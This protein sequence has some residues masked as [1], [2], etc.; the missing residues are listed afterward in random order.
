MGVEFET[1]EA[2]PVAPAEVLA[3][4]IADVRGYTSFTRERGDA[5]AAR[6]ATRFAALAGDAVAARSGEVVEV[7]GDE[8]FAVFRSAAQAVTAALELQATLAEESAADPSLPLP[9]GI[10]IA[11]G[12]AVRVGEGYRGSALNLAARLCSRAVAGQ[13][14]VSGEVFVRTAE[15]DV[16]RLQKLGHEALK[17]F[18][19]PVSVYEA[20]AAAGRLESPPRSA[21]Q[22]EPPMELT[23]ETPL[24]GREP[25]L[26]WLRGTWRSARR[27]CG[28]IV[29][30][31]G[32]AG[33]GKTSLAAALAMH[34]ADQG[35][36][37]IYSGIGGIA[38]AQVS[39]AAG[40]AGSAQR[41]TRVVLD[42]LQV[43]GATAAESLREAA[44]AIAAAP[45]LVVGL[46]DDLDASPELEDI[47]QL[48]DARGDGHRRLQPLQPSEV[49]QVARGYAPDEID[50]VPVE[51][52]A[53]RSGGM[54]AAV[55]ELLDTWV[56][57]ESARR[58]E[59]AAEWLAAGQK[60]R[61]AQL[62]FA[63]TAIERRLRRIYSPHQIATLPRDECPYQGLAPYAEDDAQWFFGRERLIGELAA[64]T[65]AT[66]LLAVVGPS[67]SGK[68]SVVRAGL[69]PSL[70]AGLLPG[71]RGWS[72]V[73]IRPGARPHAELPAGALARADSEHRLLLAVD[74]FEEVFTLCRDSVEREAFLDALVEAAAAPER[75]VVIVTIRGDYLDCV[76]EHHA[77]AELVSA[78]Q[79]LVG[80][81]TPDE[82]RRVVEQPAHRCGVRIESALADALVDEATGQPGALPLLSTA[83]VELWGQLSG[84]WLRMDAYRETGGLRGA[85]A[86]LAEASY[87]HLG[88]TEQ[89][90]A[91]R[92]FLRLAGS[93]EG[94]TVTRR[95]VDLGEF[96]TARDT[97]AGAVLDRFVADRLLTRT[98]DAVEVAHEAL[99]REW[100]RLREWLAEDAQG[101]QLHRHL[102]QAAAQW[103][104]NGRRA[105]DLYRAERLSAATE[106]S[107]THAAELNTLERE[108]LT[109]SQVANTRA[110]RRLRTGVAVLAALL[111]LSLVAGVI[112]LSQRRTAQSAATAAQR[113]AAAA[114][115][116]ARVATGQ[117]LGLQALREPEIGLSLQ[118]AAQA[119][120]IDPSSET[121]RDLVTALQHASPAVHVFRASQRL[122]ALAVT[123]DG[124][125]LAA[126]GDDSA[127][128]LYD[129]RTGRQLGRPIPQPPGGIDPPDVAFSPDGRTLAIA[130]RSPTGA[131]LELVDV[132]TRRVISTVHSGNPDHGFGSPKFTSDGR[133]LAAI[134]TRSH[135]LGPALGAELYVWRLPTLRLVGAPRRV[136]GT[137]ASLT[138]LD[139][140][141][142][143]VVSSQRMISLWNPRTVSQLRGFRVHGA[144]SDV[145]PDGRTLL[146][147]RGSGFDLIDL[148]TGAVR[149][150]LPRPARGLSGP[151]FAAGGRALVGQGRGGNSVVE[152]SL[153][154][155]RARVVGREPEVIGVLAAPTG[156][157][158]FATTLKKTAV[159]WQPG[160]GTLGHA[161]R[162][163]SPGA[164][165]NFLVVSPRGIAATEDSSFGSVRLWNLTTLRPIGGPVRIPAG[166]AAFSPDGRLLA[167]ANLLTGDVTI[168]DVVTRRVVRRLTPPRHLST[169]ALAFSP[170]GRLIAAGSLVQEGQSVLFDHG[171]VTVWD[172]HTGRVVDEF[173]QPKDGG[174]STVAF[175]RDGRRLVSVGEGGSVAVWD[176]L[177]HR[178]LRQWKTSD[179]LA[180]NAV[181]GPRDRTLA[182]GGVGGGEVTFWDSRTGRAEP[183]PIASTYNVYPAAYYNRDRSLAVASGLLGDK[184]GPGRAQLWD[185]ASRTL[186]AEF[187][188]GP[189][190][191]GVAVTPDGREMVTTSKRGIMTVLPL[192]PAVWLAAACRIADGPLTRSQWRAFIPD[193]PY[194]P[195]CRVR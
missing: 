165:T 154:T 103:D 23:S 171:Y 108:F 129:T 52:I 138:G 142:S 152:L 131:V 166:W 86:R 54:P 36:E 81:M 127:V 187:P 8:V 46:I 22:R 95:R 30:V 149:A 44:P 79:V 156:D 101:R 161:V 175:S 66:G 78:N 133:F 6:L 48:A 72:A 123:R 56:R 11:A 64:R 163:A 28:R 100:P 188:A 70:A 139:S 115:R 193:L 61:A 20:V 5:E 182:V 24:V 159:E 34:V 18:A 69:L 99:L 164:G 141:G 74:Q 90:A 15:L 130:S 49:A 19:E 55:H 114:T 180:I 153:A 113:E 63:N 4:L 191:P 169:D 12:E 111:L 16:G 31:S 181:F 151:V 158:V 1:E 173:H 137:S 89:R 148:A 93:G 140:N 107:R 26:R 104:D 47:A 50:D 25:E 121:A 195:A 105:G 57:E 117:R 119:A 150:H 87:Q 84:G 59:A 128:W 125:T 144:V 157:E 179:D 53:R 94:D 116:Q 43:T 40:R 176:P 172:A 184:T 73:T 167:V 32:G 29:F 118:L 51:S 33:I 82:Y 92:V 97:D 13:V 178:M 112:A 9:V 37:V 21:P 177:H 10:G 194:Q 155:Q 91:R 58:L 168:M 120:R 134:R 27:G 41:P 98:D 160:H 192:S 17:G 77:L 38:L 122:L 60:Q 65:V 7:R 189:G 45:A 62:Q 186:I 67:G 147:T 110:V 71:S 143:L 96:D 3:F 88:E 136:S 83:L 80:P 162:Y 126:A 170:D 190:L 76:A 146:A 145:S 132:A 42:D 14:L 39:E 2:G 68:S 109:A 85:V 35:Y 75:A 174:V 124:R 106:W 183:P 185:V 102:T 135:G